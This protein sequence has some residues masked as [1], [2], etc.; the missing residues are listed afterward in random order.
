MANDALTVDDIPVDGSNPPGGLIS[1]WTLNRPEKLN[2]LNK[3]SHTAIK[4]Q[5]SRA[6]SDPNVRC[7]VIRGAPPP[8]A[9]EGKRQKP[10]AFAAWGGYFRVFW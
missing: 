5:C 8:P 6:E 2:A 7:I 4:E 3:D 9:E 1:V 10:A